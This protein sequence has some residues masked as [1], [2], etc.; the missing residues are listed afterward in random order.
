MSITGK[1][2]S[3]GYP[4]YTKVISHRNNTIYTVRIAEISRNGMTFF[5]DLHTC[6]HAQMYTIKKKNQENRTHLIRKDGL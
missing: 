1:G 4:Q 3:E 2:L 5:T 6:V